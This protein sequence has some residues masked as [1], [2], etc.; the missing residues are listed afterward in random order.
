MTT[1]IAFLRGLNVGSH[2]RMRMDELRALFESLE[3]AD[4]QTY[5]QSGN[6]VFE[7]GETDEETLRD[8]V[9]D[10]IQDAFGDDVSVMIRSRTQLRDAVTGQPFDA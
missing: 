6:V 9:H 7:T 2:N 1:Y 4:V 3:Y 10:A 5:V 8:D